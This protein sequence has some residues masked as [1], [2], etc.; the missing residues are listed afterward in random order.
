MVSMI[1]GGRTLDT[2]I[3]AVVALYACTMPKAKAQTKS[4]LE[5]PV[6][7][8][9][10]TRKEYLEVEVLEEDQIFVIAVR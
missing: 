7:W 8:P 6:V 1:R 10:I 4:V 9:S 3:S 5:A 2:E